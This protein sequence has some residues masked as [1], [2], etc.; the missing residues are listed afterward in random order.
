MNSKRVLAF[1]GAL[2]ATAGLALGLVFGLALDGSPAEEEQAVARVSPA[3]STGP[4]DGIKVHG[5]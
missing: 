1:V 2:A 4:S 5:H 3:S